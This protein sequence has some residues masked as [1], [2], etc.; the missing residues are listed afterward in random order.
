MKAKRKLNVH[1]QYINEQTCMLIIFFNNYNLCFFKVRVN[2]LVF[3]SLKRSVKEEQI[4][5]SQ[6]MITKRPS[7]CQCQGINFVS[8]FLKKALIKLSR[9]IIRFN[10][11]LITF[12]SPTTSHQQD[13]SEDLLRKVFFRD[14]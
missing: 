10:I 14:S 5:E 12:V 2:I 13:H 11:Y 7:Q 6:N 4:L 3:Y 9:F 8:L 1:P